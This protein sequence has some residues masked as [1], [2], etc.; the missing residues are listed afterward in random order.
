MIVFSADVCC[1]IFFFTGSFMPPHSLVRPLAV[2][3]WWMQ[4]EP[5]AFVVSVETLICVACACASATGHSAVC[6]ACCHQKGEYRGTKREDSGA[7]DSVLS[8]SLS[9]LLPTLF[10]FSC[11]GCKEM[12]FKFTF[13]CSCFGKSC[14]VVYLGIILRNCPFLWAVAHNLLFKITFRVWH[15]PS[16]SYCLCSPLWRV[17][18]EEPFWRKAFSSFLIASCLWY[19][20][21]YLSC[22]LSHLPLSSTCSGSTAKCWHLVYCSWARFGILE[23]VQHRQESQIFSAACSC[24]I[25][26]S[27]WWLKTVHLGNL[28][29]AVE[30]CFAACSDGLLACCL[31]NNSSI[32]T[33]K[34]V[35]WGSSF[36]CANLSKSG[37]LHLC[38]CTLL[39][40]K[41]V[42]NGGIVRCNH[43]KFE[44]SVMFFV[45]AVF[46]W[47][48]FLEN[49]GVCTALDF[50]TN[51]HLCI[52]SVMCTR[53]VYINI[54]IYT[55][56]SRT[57]LWGQAV[58][59]VSRRNVLLLCVKT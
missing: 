4:D 17:R 59:Y 6:A 27:L 35:H 44:I 30:T 36:C 40:K 25:S 14:F 34:P 49:I 10:S 19:F 32:A 13:G 41:C 52:A 53:N 8:R 21:N 47:F 5:T 16:F 1:S 50:L 12:S 2:E 23:H 15:L 31:L 43:E 55:C 26:F 33:M 39:L 20:T 18:K 7:P 42:L 38:C 54:G 28:C 46:L 45:P 37:M 48:G 22:F 9:L 3:T 24:K 51:C 29:K 58:G 56:V 57:F 11:E